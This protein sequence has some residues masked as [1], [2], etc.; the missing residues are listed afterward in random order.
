VM[1]FRIFGDST[2][3]RVQDKLT[4]YHH[5]DC[6]MPEAQN[7][8]VCINQLEIKLSSKF[9]STMTFTKKY[10]KSFRGNPKRFYSFMRNLQQ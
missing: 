8:K 9:V 10:I 4:H 1:I 7:T 6:P 2:S 3:S 5:H